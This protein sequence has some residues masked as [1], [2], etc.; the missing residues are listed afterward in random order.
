MRM[1]GLHDAPEIEG[2]EASFADVRGASEVVYE[3]TGT[4]LKESIVLAAAPP[5]TAPQSYTYTLDASASLT[6]VLTQS[7]AVEFRREDGTVSVAIPAGNMTDSAQ[8]PAYTEAVAYQLTPTATGWTLTVT[9]SHDWLTDPAR[10]F[11]V[12]IDPTLSQSVARDC[13][14]GEENPTTSACGDM[15]QFL[16]VGRKSSTRTSAV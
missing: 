10:V 13:W 5:A 2:T 4:G 6:P 3:A 11:P 1:H 14:V 16:R 7:G 15:A 8:Q 12:V 9:P